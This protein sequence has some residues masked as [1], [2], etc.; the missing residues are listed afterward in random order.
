MVQTLLSIFPNPADL[1]ALE[2]E[3]LGGVI[4]EVAPG[5]M[6]H[7]IFNDG[8][9]SAQLFP[10]VG[11]GYQHNVHRP[12]ELALAEALSWLESQGLIVIDPGQP[13]K[14]YVLTRRAKTLRTRA[15][16]EAYRKG[17]IL[18]VELLQPRLAD[19]VWPLFLRGDHDVAV[20]QAF[21]EIEVAVRKASNIKGA[22]YPDDL[23][24]V[25]LMRKAFNPDTGPLRDD[26]HVIGERDAEMHLFAGAIGHAKNPTS[27]RDVNLTPQESARLIVF[28]SHLLDI[29]EHRG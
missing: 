15:D 11:T 13:L 25:A 27:H 12:V 8:Y 1:L 6:Q 23:L 19:K 9:L 28:A 10:A 24:G 2:P 20:F 4:L 18:P 7:G 3:E 21:K 26:V 5:V 29:V 22:N 17:R 14:S 16:V